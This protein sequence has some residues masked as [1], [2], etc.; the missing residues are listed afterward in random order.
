MSTADSQAPRTLD[1]LLRSRA[2]TIPDV[3][4]AAYP[5]SAEPDSYERHTARQLDRYA[6]AAAHHYRAVFGNRTRNA[7]ERV[8]ALL[9]VSD[10]DYLVAQFALGRLGFT[11]LLLSTRLSPEAVCSLLDKTN[12][13]DLVYS[14]S[15]KEKVEAVSAVLPLRSTPL[16]GDYRGEPG[17]PIELDLDPEFET[18]TS[19][20]I[21]HSSG[22]TGFPKPIRNIHKSYLYNA[23]NN[24]GLRGF[25]TLP[26]Y[27]N[28]GMSSFY[29]ALHAGKVLYFYNPT[30]PL[31][32]RQLTAVF[33]HLGAELEIFYGVP[34]ALKVLATPDG[35]QLLKRFKVVM[36]GGSA[37]PDDLGDMLVD[38][39]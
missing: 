15:L 17:P 19:C 21:M 13:R 12:C 28:H 20:H 1:E 34:Y 31:S 10:L 6:T 11:V 30:L 18:S 9:A 23:A 7:P 5:T 3:P 4:I 38:A 35:L 22:S 26:L 16:L 27:H 39:G 14:T 32:A 29:R 8:I 33:K 37:C 24:F 25:I 36:F 2:A